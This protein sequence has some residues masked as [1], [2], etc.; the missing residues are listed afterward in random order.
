[1][2]ADAERLRAIVA[3]AQPRLVAIGPADAAR[4]PAAADSWSKQ[5]ILG[6]LIDSAVNN[7]A[8]FVR[9]QLQAEVRL[10]AYDSPE[11]VR[12]QDYAAA[13]WPA[14]VELWAAFNRHLAH[15]LDRIPSHRM[16][17]PCRIGDAAPV[18]LQALIVSYGDHLLH[19]LQQIDPEIR[20]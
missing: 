5:E 7:H 20:G 15:V 4:Q 17:V 14:L 8:R 6:H 16:S 11:W 12:V 10:P 3:R 19:H 2:S 9:A 1:M 18:T 13:E